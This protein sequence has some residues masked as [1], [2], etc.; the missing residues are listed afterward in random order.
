MKTSLKLA[1]FLYSILYC[2]ILSAQAPDCSNYGGV[3]ATILEQEICSNFD[4]NFEFEFTPQDPDGAFYFFE[5]YGSDGSIGF[6]DGDG[7]FGFG[8]ATPELIDQCDPV[9]IDYFADVFC[10]VTGEVIEAGISLG[11]VLVYPNFTVEVELPGCDDESATGSATLVTEFGTVCDG[12]ILGVSG[13]SGDCET[14]VPATLDYVFD[15]FPGTLCEITY[16][17]NISIPCSTESLGCTDDTAC[18][19]DPEATCDDGSCDFT[20]PCCPTPIFDEIVPSICAS[21]G[22]DEPILCVSF[23]GDVAGI[24]EE[25]A[26]IDNTNGDFGFEIF[27]D[28]ISNQVCFEFSTINEE[29][30]PIDTEFFISYECTNGNFFNTSL[31]IISIYPNLTL[32]EP[33][34]EPSGE[35][36]GAPLIFPNICGDVLLGEETPPN[37]ECDILTAG[38]IEW[39]I[40]PLFDITDAPACF[41]LPTGPTPIVPCG[42]DCPCDGTFCGATCFDLT[43]EVGSVPP[44]ACSFEEAIIGITVTGNGADLGSYDVI[45]LAGNIFVGSIFHTPGDPTDFEISGFLDNF[46]CIPIDYNL[47]Y[48][49]ICGEDGSDLSTG[50]I[51]TVTVYPDIFLFF[52]EEGLAEP[53]TAPQFLPAPCGTVI[54]DPDPIP[55]PECGSDGEDQFIPWTVDVGF[56][57]TDAPPCFDVNILQGELF[58]PA[59]PLDEGEPC[60][61][62][63]L[64]E[65]VI[66]NCLCVVADAPTLELVGDLP[67]GFCEGEPISLNVNVLG[68]LSTDPIEVIIRDL[69]F[70]INTSVFVDENTPLPVT[71]DIFPFSNDA[72]NSSTYELVLEARCS[73]DFS[74]IYGPEPLGTITVY[75]S[76]SNFAPIEIP[77]Q[78]CGELPVVTPNDFCGG[79]ITTEVVL[80]VDDCEAPVAGSLDW[81]LVPPFDITDAPACFTDELS[82]SIGIAPCLVDCP[83]DGVQCGGSCLE[84]T[85][86]VDGLP[87][88]VCPDQPVSLTVDISGLGADFGEYFISIESNG[89]NIGFINHFAGDPT[90]YIV[91][92]FPFNNSCEVETQEVTY[93]LT[94][95]DGAVI[96]TGIVGS[97]TVYPSLF[98]FF[99][100]ITPSIA[101]VQELEIIEPLCGTLILDPITIPQLGCG[102]EDEVV[103]WSIDF[104]FDYPADCNIEPISGVETVFACVGEEGDPCD[105]NNPCTANDVLDADC[106]CAG[107]GPTVAT[108]DVLPAFTCT[109]E[110]FSITAT[111][112]GDIPD[113]LFVVIDDQ[114]GNFPAFGF[115]NP[116]DGNTI[117][118]DIIFFTQLACE[119]TTY[120]FTLELLCPETFTT[121]GAPVSLGSTTVYPSADQ[122]LPTIEPAILCGEEPTI[123]AGFCGDLILDVTPAD[124]AACPAGNDGFVDWT[125][126]T[127]LDLANAPA[128]FDATL[129]TGQEQII[130]C[131]N[132]CPALVQAVVSEPGIY[133][134]GDVTLFCADFADPFTSDGEV[135]INGVDAIA[136]ETQICFDLSLINNTC[137]FTDIAVPF[138]VLCTTDGS[139]ST[140]FT[141]PITIAPDPS[142][143]EFEVVSGGCGFAP[144]VRST[145]GNCFVSSGQVTITV[146]PIDGCPPQDGEVELTLDYFDDDF[147]IIDISQIPCPGFTT[148]I[149]AP[150]PGCSDC[151]CPA[152]PIITSVDTDVCEGN[153][154]QVCLTFAPGDEANS[155]GTL[156][157]V[158]G[159]LGSFYSVNLV[160]DGTAL[161]YCIEF[162][163]NFFTPVECDPVTEEYLIDVFCSNLDPIVSGSGPFPTTIYPALDKF[164][165]EIIPTTDNCPDA[166]ALPEVVSIGECD[167]DIQS[168]V[169]IM[170]VDGCPETAGEFTYSVNYL[171]PANFA[172]A[173]ADCAFAS[174]VDATE[175]IPACSTCTGY[176][177]NICFAEF[178]P[179]PGPDDFVDIA[180]CVTPL[181]CADNPDASC[182]T[183]TACTGDCETGDEITITANGEVCTAC[184]PE[185]NSGCTDPAACNFDVAATCDDG[186]CDFGNPAC[187]DPCNAILGCT[188]VTACNYDPDATCEDGNCD[189]GNP[190]C[191]DP[192]NAILGCTDATAC[193]YDPDATCEDGNC[194]FGVPACPDPCNAILGCTDVTACN[195]DPDATCEDGNCD[196][197]VPA[198]PDPCNEMLGCTDVTACNYDPDATCDDGNCDFGVLACPDPCNA[199]LGC[200]DVTACNYDPDATC[201]DG[202]CDF[203]V[204]ACPDPCNEML[205]CTDLTACNYNPD[206]CVDDGSCDLGNPA[207]PDPCNAI[208]GCTDATACNF[209][210]AATCEDGSC[211]FGVPAC[212]DPCNAILGCTDATAGNYNPIAT[213]DDGSCVNP[214]CNGFIVLDDV[215]ICNTDIGSGEVG[216][217]LVPVN[218]NANAEVDNLDG[219]LTVVAFDLYDGAGV[220][221]SSSIESA[222]LSSSA[223][224]PLEILLPLNESCASVTYDYSVITSIKTV[225]V[226][227]GMIIDSTDDPDCTAETFTITIYP[228]LTATD[229]SAVDCSDRQVDLLAEDGTVCESQTQACAADNDALNADFTA[230][231]VDPLGCS[232]LT[233]TSAACNACTPICTDPIYA[234]CV[235]LARACE[236]NS[237]YVAEVGADCSTGYPTPLAPGA[238]WIFEWYLDGNL[239]ATNTGQPYFSPSTVGNY[240]VI[241][242]DLESCEFWD[243]AAPCSGIVVDKIIDCSDCGGK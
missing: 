123:T 35:C 57:I 124:A 155:V 5:I 167:L 13:V 33:F 131:S 16:E 184:E 91:D 25:S 240:T 44:S 50:T 8:F 193:N 224:D 58:I 190:A 26:F 18:N 178:N 40:D 32:F 100:Q 126:D 129:L 21:E 138:E 61:V 43:V 166:A 137:S 94:C 77:G 160:G 49:I 92:V 191:P 201:E 225:N 109:N 52:P 185:I 145:D 206:A 210:V 63:C 151:P 134:S 198:C 143:W 211:D 242:T 216:V 202:N 3:T 140:A 122:F 74:L 196:F 54:T 107:E 99:P 101:C 4:V 70:N 29:C 23:D 199:I 85:V 232:I 121:I 80:P 217:D 113:G 144:F 153:V 19:F 168:A 31:G 55:N 95:S 204:P 79:D 115:L 183:T 65:G 162:T 139:V 88:E 39:T 159:N 69:N 116:G 243:T 142:N 53:C 150:Q 147:N 161:D 152:E 181:G 48:T 45:V 1:V 38:S 78:A 146:P 105:D 171:T 208:L 174:V 219:T 12:P 56:D 68:T 11:T 86:A 214:D 97:I 163:P 20:E 197:G 213:C 108:T 10:E 120:D 154:V 36:G 241:I 237:I 51:G 222:T 209:D 156:V 229:V 119:I 234:G 130:A 34:I 165:Y 233:A 83:C 238:N 41:V 192:C 188:D 22:T 157:Q 218:C 125:V 158:S 28:P 187:P 239:V 66:E 117:Q 60:E 236:S 64:G 114:F 169:T 81:V 220:L 76:P 195:Y 72:C 96:G 9:S 132:C 226:V 179:S 15:P 133:C 59:C 93:S 73:F 141:D 82:G 176:C 186:S 207:C 27:S 230:T 173:P 205:G 104:G 46:T 24:V 84:L 170:P 175:P 7:F 103:N 203:G 37:N 110:Q 2:F 221:I 75:P 62:A 200:T 212:P 102:G 194:D 231:I 6:G 106:N 127:G 67:A 228:I 17:D 87:A 111:I 136:G 227:D 223:C 128:C 71:L 148:T 112:T 89:F 14:Q 215:E 47:T 149:T 180:L 235:C 164:A 135:I 172:N 98:N 90:S 118:L 182:L 42:E 30:E 177:D 189:F